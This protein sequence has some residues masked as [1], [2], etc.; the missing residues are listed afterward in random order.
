MYVPRNMQMDIAQCRRFINAHPF[1]LLMSE[2]PMQATHVPFVLHQDDDNKDYLHCHFAKA[3]P[4]WHEIDDKEV[5]V[6]FSGPHAYISPTWYE[7]KPAVPTW[8]YAAVHVRAK[9]TLLSANQNAGITQELLEIYE[10]DNL[11]RDDILA[12]DYLNKLNQVIVSLRLDVIQM[13]GKA[14]LGQQRSEADQ[15]GVNRAL[16]QSSRKDDQAY[17]AF[18][19]DWLA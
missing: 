8:N 4:H 14:K 17:A 5:L 18:A 1:A 15:A 6:V 7:T 11:Q 9:A 13:Q 16:E 10:A 12:P 3:N 2:Q 19:K